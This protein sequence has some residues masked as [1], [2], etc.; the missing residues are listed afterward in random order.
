MTLKSKYLTT[1]LQTSTK[2]KLLLLRQAVA[3]KLDFPDP[4]FETRQRAAWS[5][6]ATRTSSQR[7]SLWLTTAPL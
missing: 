5:V 7:V 2:L 4:F 3:A 6:D 1:Y